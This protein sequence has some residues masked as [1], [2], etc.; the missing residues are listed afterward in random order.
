MDTVCSCLNRSGSEERK[1]MVICVFQIATGVSSIVISIIADMER[2][3]KDSHK[4]ASLTDALTEVYN[5]RFFQ[6]RLDE[7]ITR[8]RR[9]GRPIS[10]L[11]VDVNSFKAINDEFGH[12]EGA[13]V[14]RY[15][16]DG[17]V[18]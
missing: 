14:C 7:E 11:L 17:I 10:L 2:F 5:N 4:E 12:A 18:L 1:S 9:S 13:I 6:L 15:G 8:A 16:R 3:K